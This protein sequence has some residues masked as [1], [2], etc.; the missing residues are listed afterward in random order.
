[1]PIPGI[2][3]F[4]FRGPISIEEEGNELI[5]EYWLISTL[6]VLIEKY[7]A[8]ASPYGV[9][10]NSPLLVSTVL[11]L[12]E[13]SF[14]LNRMPTTGARFERA[15]RLWRGCGLRRMPMDREQTFDTIKPYTLEEAYEVLEAIDNRD[16]PN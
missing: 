12:Q 1:M 4:G 8:C 11:P 15:V 7:R 6:S 16:W 2:K 9:Q 3:F 10:R 5:K 13:R 14:T